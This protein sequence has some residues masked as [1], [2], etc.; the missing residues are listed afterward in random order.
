MQAGNRKNKPLTQQAPVNGA[1][2]KQKAVLDGFF[3]QKV[4][5]I[6]PFLLQLHNPSRTATPTRPS[7]RLL[8]VLDFYLFRL[9]FEA[10]NLFQRQARLFRQLLK[11]L[12][13]L[14]F[15]LLL[16]ESN[17]A[18]NFITKSNQIF[19]RHLFK[20]FQILCRHLQPP[21]GLFLF[22]TSDKII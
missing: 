19:N 14:R 5:K 22:D 11:L 3:H 20:V 16:L 18:L 4:F 7:A 13:Q 12:F 8:A 9:L 10:Q 21:L 6:A 2:F 15:L 17:K 1:C